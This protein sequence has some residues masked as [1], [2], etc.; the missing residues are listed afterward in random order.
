MPQRAVIQEELSPKY[1]DSDL[2]RFEAHL[3]ERGLTW[4]YILHQRPHARQFLDYI[5]GL[6][7]AVDT[8]QRDQVSAYFRVALRIYKKHKP[9]RLKSACYWRMISRR[10]V[11]ALLRFVQGEW[12]PGSRQAPILA[13]FRGELEQLR[14]NR[15]GMPGY[16]SKARQFLRY[17]REQG[18]SIEEARPC[19]LDDFLQKKLERYRKRHGRSPKQP[20][21]WRSEYTGP[22]HR[23][24][25]MVQP[26]W[27]PAESPANDCE[28][29]HHEVCDGYGRWLSEVN[30][31]S[32]W[33]LLKNGDAAKLFLRWLGERADRESLARVSIS[34][35]DAY[36]E[37]RMEGLRRATRWGV[38][39]CLRSF[40]RYLN[41][42]GFIPRDLSP[43]VSGPTLYKFEEIPRAFTEQQVE[44]LLETTRRDLRPTGRRDYAMLML[45]AIYGLR[46]G[47]VVRLRLEDIDWRG[48]RLRVRHSKTGNESLLP[49][50]EPVGEA[51]LEYLQQGRPKTDVREV[52]LRACAPHGPFACAGSIGTV[53]NNRMKQAGIDVKG[54]HGCH[55]FRF[56]R[57]ISLLRASVPLKSIGD[58]L[59]HCTESSTAIYLRLPTDGLR[60]ISLEVPRKD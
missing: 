49:L 47:E 10:S 23:L 41:V 59:G 40:L 43:A 44:K 14:Y 9:N 1:R 2:A 46:A 60:A 48:Q 19:H 33:T 36:L 45:L 18:T 37:W 35:I 53:I 52:F 5:K 27:P 42:A 50:V 34:D 3:T 54:R 16:M 21:Q 31:L 30:G 51:L 8:V 25:R 28:R 17:L 11:Y 38:S 15:P 22:I 39:G 58:L 55:A 29:F 26:R 7:I 57:A 56:A 20:R 6:G 32:Q 13:R 24:L 12:P 4:R